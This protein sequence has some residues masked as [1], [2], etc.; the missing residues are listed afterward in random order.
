MAR[1]TRRRGGIDRPVKRTVRRV[2]TTAR[3]RAPA[4]PAPA[5]AYV[6]SRRSR[7]VRGT[8]HFEAAD[9]MTIGGDDVSSPIFDLA[10]RD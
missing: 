4:A 1:T 3:R 2:K 8:R 5:G 7:C 6:G 10:R 9:Q